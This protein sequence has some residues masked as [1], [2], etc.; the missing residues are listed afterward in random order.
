MQGVTELK[1]F[2]S[3]LPLIRYVKG[4]GRDEMGVR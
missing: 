1:S 2:A 4:S 3:W